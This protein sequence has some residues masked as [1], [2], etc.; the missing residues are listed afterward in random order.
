MYLSECRVVNM[1]ARR[2]PKIPCSW[3]YR[4]MSATGNG[5][6]DQTPVSARTA[7]TLNH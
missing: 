4:Y 2:E 7:N 5:C 6:W 3:S 1:E